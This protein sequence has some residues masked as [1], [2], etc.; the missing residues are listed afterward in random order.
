MGRARGAACRRR[1]PSPGG[2]APASGRTARSP[3]AGR[4]C[5]RRGRSRGPPA[6]QARLAFGCGSH[7]LSQ[8]RLAFGCG[9]HSLSQARLAFGCGSH[10]H[11]GLADH[12]AEVLVHGGVVGELRVEGGH[13]DA[14][15]PRHHRLVAVGGERLDAG[16]DAPDAR[17]ADEDHLDRRGA[18]LEGRATARLEGLALPAV[19]VALDPDVDEAERELRGAL[20]LPRQENQPG[21]GAEDRPPLGVELLERRHEPPLVHE[22]E[23]RRALAPGNDEAVDVRELLGLADFARLDAAPPQR[24]G[25]EV[26]VAL[27]REDADFHRSAR[28]GGRRSARTL[29]VISPLASRPRPSLGSHYHPRVCI[30]SF[31]ASL[32]VSMP[33]IASPRSSLTFT[34]TAGSLKCVV[35]CTM[36]FARLAGSDDLKMPEPTNTASAPSCIISAASAGVAMPPAEK[37]GTGSLPAWATQR[38]R[39]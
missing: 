24:L 28:A 20:H 38:T 31:S 18:A 36:A 7:S 14:A 15:L 9:S 8:A 19:R 26:E 37:F 16:A 22:F 39:S 17:G 27:Q 21:A 2:R 34:S 3:R 11:P 13:Q 35:A 32:E 33:T 23:Q 6:S 12:R 10:S 5:R 1:P 29:S 25:V 4:S 30:R